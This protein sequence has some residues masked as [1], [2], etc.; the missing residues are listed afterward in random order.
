MVSVVTE[1]EYVPLFGAGLTKDEVIELNGELEELL[2]ALGLDSSRYFYRPLDEYRSPVDLYEEIGQKLDEDGQDVDLS[3]TL[4]TRLG[5]DHPLVVELRRR[6]ALGDVRV[7][8]EFVKSGLGPENAEKVYKKT[9]NDFRTPLEYYSYLQ[10][11][12]KENGLNLV[13]LIKAKLGAE[14]PL[15]KALG[16]DILDENIG[17]HSMKSSKSFGSR[18]I[19]PAEGAA[20]EEATPPEEATAPEETPKEETEKKEP[21]VLGVIENTEPNVP[22]EK[23]KVGLEEQ[24]DSEKEQMVKED[25]PGSE[26]KPEIANVPEAGPPKADIIK[27][28]DFTPGRD[29]TAPV[30][31]PCG[32]RF[33]NCFGMR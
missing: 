18:K 6:E 4:A 24:P 21:K 8:D 27:E 3:E 26:N 5:D 23:E 16:G 1:V 19:E 14:H 29:E 17:W 33:K 30:R 11:R 28:R 31:A 15:L 25:D 12:A 13:P 2:T 20:P 7:L 22:E 32:C 9:P 10:D